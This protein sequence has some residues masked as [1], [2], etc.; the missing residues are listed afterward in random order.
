MKMIITRTPFRVSLAGG[1]S[2]LP[3]Y[4]RLRGGAVLSFAVDKYMYLSMHP[5]FRRSGFLLKYS[6]VESVDTVEEIRHRVIRQVFGDYGINGVDFNSAADV[7]AGTGLGSSSAFTVGLSLLC[8]IF[9]GRRQ[10]N[11]QLAAY[12]CRVEIE[13]L[14]DPIGKQDQYACAHGGINFIR[15]NP[16]DSV[17]VEKVFLPPAKAE[18][19]ENNLALFY[20]GVTRSAGSILSGQKRNMQNGGAEVNA[21]GRLVE[22]A[23]ELEEELRRGNID[24]VGDVLDRGW[25]Y[26][27]EMAS[28]ISNPGIDDLH[29]RAMRAGAA[30][31]KLL[32]AG[33]GGFL[34]FYAP[35][36]KMDAVRREL[37]EL[38][39]L[40]FRFEKSGTTLA[41]HD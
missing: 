41:F 32:G 13:K 16:D 27:K 10:T 38:P 19:L 34:L 4:Y 21:V 1:G 29:A 40:P 24:A 15:F 28:G 22:L 36:D 8:D 7:P 9:T 11:D 31:G 20:T 35:G 37:A 2:D 30:G 26:K 18:E 12:A 39:E 5:N 23:E 14:G 25:R 3:D 6:Q 33:G 17:Q